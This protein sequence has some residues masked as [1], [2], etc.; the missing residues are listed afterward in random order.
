M[1]TA[2]RFRVEADGIL[3]DNFGDGLRPETAPFGIAGGKGPEPSKLLVRRPDGSVED[4]DVHK[5]VELN[6]GDIYEID[7]A[8]G[9]GYGNPF[10]RPIEKVLDDV[11][12]GLVSVEKARIDYGVVVD[13]TTLILDVPATEKLRG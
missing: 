11:L 6:T 10:E 2:Y 4:P 13:P 1:G 7:E 5:Y 12:D 8:G 9:G 3:S